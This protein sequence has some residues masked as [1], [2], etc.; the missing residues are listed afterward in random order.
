VKWCKSYLLMENKFDIVS[1]FLA[2]PSAFSIL[3]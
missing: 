3:P 1:V 2:P